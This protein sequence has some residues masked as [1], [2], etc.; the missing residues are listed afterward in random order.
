M[1]D[2]DIKW[3]LGHQFEDMLMLTQFAYENASNDYEHIFDAVHGNCYT[4][5]YLGLKKP[6][7]VVRSGPENGEF[8]S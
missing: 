4:F 8:F 3:S 7:K 2:L 6:Y 5:N 1:E